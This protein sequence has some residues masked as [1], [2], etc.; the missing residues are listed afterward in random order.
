MRVFFGCATA[1]WMK[2]DG[3]N[4]TVSVIIV[5]WNTAGLLRDCLRK[6]VVALRGLDAEVV[7]VDNASAC[8]ELPQNLCEALQLR[9]IRNP[10]NTGFSFA[11][12][13]GADCAAGDYLLF[14]NPDAGLA[15]GAVKALLRCVQHEAYGAVAATP[16]DSYGNPSMP[17][18]NFLTPFNHALELLGLT[19]F[20]RRS[21]VAQPGPPLCHRVDWARASTLLV[22]ARLFAEVGGFNEG[23]F[24]Y[25]EDEDLAWRLRRRG[26]F[27]G[28]CAC[29][30]TVDNGGAATSLRPLWAARRLYRAQFEFVR[31]RAGAAAARLYLLCTRTAL[32]LKRFRAR[33]SEP[34]LVYGVAE[35]NAAL[36]ELKACG[37]GSVAAG[38]GA[39]FASQED[40]C[41]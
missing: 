31:N 39:D 33:F 7:V 16:H 40:G 3:S 14:L 32:S 20:A 8:A 2:M 10:V 29:A 36:A 26:Y 22:P 6:L 18:F 9:L 5:H 23:Y 25:E 28:V 34:A 41:R 24:F 4:P 27:V 13:Q 11:A 12:N 30:V 35:L 19:F 15:P 38:D 37:H 21:A 17:A 1:W